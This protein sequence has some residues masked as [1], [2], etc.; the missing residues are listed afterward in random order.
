MNEGVNDALCSALPLPPCAI[1]EGNRVEPGCFKIACSGLEKQAQYFESLRSKQALLSML[2]S[3]LRDV[4]DDRP[5]RVWRLIAIRSC[6]NI[7]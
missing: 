7:A 4:T 5:G 6:R 2:L 3:S 1:N